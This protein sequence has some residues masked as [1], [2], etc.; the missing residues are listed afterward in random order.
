MP[1]KNYSDSTR[2]YGAY[3]RFY[4]DKMEAIQAL[5]IDTGL[6]A[7][8]AQK[9]IDALFSTGKRSAAAAARRFEDTAEVDVAHYANRYYPSK[10]DAIRAL[11]QLGVPE[12]DAVNAIEEAFREI[13][14]DREAN[15][16]KNTRQA[17]KK[18]GKGL[19]LAAFFCGYG[20]FYTISRLVKPYMGKRR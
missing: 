15:R 8:E 13:K 11:R 5:R 17:A 20:F 14:T 19:G 4:P 3:L 12:A 18:A 6:N 7:V 16:R 1:Q 2:D 10:P 9:I